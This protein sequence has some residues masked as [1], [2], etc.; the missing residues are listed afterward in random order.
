MKNVPV[1]D[2]GGFMLDAN[3]WLY[4]Y[5]DVD[6]GNYLTGIY[7][8][9]L[10]LAKDQSLPLFA[11]PVIVSEFHNR[12]LRASHLMFCQT[13]KD[14]GAQEPNWKEF[15]SSPEGREALTAAAD[16][17]SYILE[18]CSVV[19]LITAGDWLQETCDELANRNLE[20]NDALIEKVCKDNGL[21]LV[22]HDGDFAD[23]SVTLYSGNRRLCSP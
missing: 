14:D 23:T 12:I 21:A 11:T 18:D 8:N 15:R 9:F 16:N 1:G 5:G 22:T 20:L 17:V 4:L 10:K 2:H 7:S 3:I 13:C 19:D 6:Y